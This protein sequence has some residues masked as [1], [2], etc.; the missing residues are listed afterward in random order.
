[1]KLKLTFGRYSDYLVRMDFDNRV[2]LTF[3]LFLVLL[4][5]IDLLVSRL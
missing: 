2:R 5:L 3:F 1:M 4:F